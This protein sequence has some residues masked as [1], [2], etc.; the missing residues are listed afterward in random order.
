[1][2]LDTTLA[3]SSSCFKHRCVALLLF[4][5]SGVKVIEMLLA[6]ANCSSNDW[7]VFRRDK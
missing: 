1:M 3:S 4:V 6:T 2:V 5:N 7:F